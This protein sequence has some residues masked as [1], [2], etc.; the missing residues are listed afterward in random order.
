MLREDSRRRRQIALTWQ[1]DT[2]SLFLFGRDYNLAEAPVDVGWRG[3]AADDDRRRR[4]MTFQ[5]GAGLIESVRTRQHTQGGKHKQIKTS[6]AWRTQVRE[7]VTGDTT[8]MSRRR[9]PCFLAPR[10][11]LTL[12]NIRYLLPETHLHSSY[13]FLTNVHLSTD[14]DESLTRRVLASG[15]ES[16]LAAETTDVYRLFTI[17]ETPTKKESAIAC[18]KNSPSNRLELFRKTMKNRNPDGRTGVRTQVLPDASR[19]IYHCDASLGQ[20][21]GSLAGQ[22]ANYRGQ[23]RKPHAAAP[24]RRDPTTILEVVSRFIHAKTRVSSTFAPTPRLARFGHAFRVE[25][26]EV[27]NFG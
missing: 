6:D 21:R 14:A 17:I 18:S 16:T 25:W 8:E 12:S 3:A 5:A 22:P 7:G 24:T 13:I 26:S 1:F 10:C 11:A 4:Q 27:E 23:Q 15:L 2:N 19:K 9:G 20:R